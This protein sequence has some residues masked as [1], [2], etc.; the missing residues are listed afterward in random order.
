MCA[1]QSR[2]AATIPHRPGCAGSHKRRRSA[3]RH[4][5][6][7]RCSS[8]GFITWYIRYPSAICAPIVETASA[9]NSTGGPS[10]APAAGCRWPDLLELVER[11]GSDTGG[12]QAQ[13]QPRG[14]VRQVELT[15][16][17]GDGQDPGAAE[18]RDRQA[19]RVVGLPQQHLPAPLAAPVTVGVGWSVDLAGRAHD[20]HVGVLNKP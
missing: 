14:H 1:W 12:H 9:V 4:I 10:S 6:R 16:L 8:W 19:A 17:Y 18:H 15:R 11:A 3:S 20:P 13:H 2:S 7:V 5:R